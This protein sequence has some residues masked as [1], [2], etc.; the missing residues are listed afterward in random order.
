[1]Q[2]IWSYGVD[3]VRKGSSSARKKKGYGT[4][5]FYRSNFVDL[6]ERTKKYMK[7]TF[8]DPSFGL[9]R[10]SKGQDILKLPFEAQEEPV[11]DI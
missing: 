11:S 2:N 8:Q 1:M 6:D 3:D 4:K 5:V 10:A 7:L 9:Q